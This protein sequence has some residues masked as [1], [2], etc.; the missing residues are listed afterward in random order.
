MGIEP[1]PY[2]YDSHALPAELH[3]KIN[4]IRASPYPSPMQSYSANVTTSLSFRE[5]PY[6]SCRGQS[7]CRISPANFT[8]LSDVFSQFAIEETFCLL[9]Y[10]Y[11]NEFLV[12]YPDFSGSRQINLFEMFHLV[13]GLSHHSHQWIILTP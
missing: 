6:A 10:R 9:P 4:M 12:L 11:F 3:S 2:D 7:T 5:R 1:M 8:V 13:R